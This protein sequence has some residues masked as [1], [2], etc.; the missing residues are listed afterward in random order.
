MTHDDG[1]SLIRFLYYA[2]WFDT[3]AIIVTN[4]LPDFKH[5]DTGPWDKAMGILNAYKEDLPQLRKHDSLFPNYEELLSKTKQGRGALP[6]IW[7]TNDLKFSGQI[8][9]RYVESKWDSINFHDWIGEG[10]NPNGESKDSEGSEFLQQVFDKDDDRPIYVQAWGGPI[11]LVQALYRYKQRKGDEKLK[12]ILSK[13]HIYG[14]LF[15]DITFE[16]FIDF[17]SVKNKS[18]GGFGSAIPTYKGERAELGQLLYDPGHFWQ[19][20]CSSDSNWVR[21]IYAKEFKGHGAMSELFDDYGEGDT[22]SFLYLISAKL[23]LNDPL[24][25]TQGSWGNR[26]SQMEKPF[27]KGYYHSCNHNAS[28][29][30]RWN[31]EAKNSF[32][33]RLL[34]SV[35]N[36]EE[37]NREPVAV[38]NRDNSNKIIT[39]YVTPGKSI[40]LDATKSSDTDRDGLTF[41]W[42]RYDEADNYD[43][44]FGLTEPANAIQ[45]L[46]VPSDLNDKN[47]HLVL[48]V[49]DNGTP[50]LAVYRRV[51]IKAENN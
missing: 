45:K 28:E 29:L 23:G 37:V 34:W 31:S 38:V 9:S 46:V 30:T 42:F 43:G 5:T 51:I 47:I 10:L 17:D 2:P 50:G 20:C 1:N 35:K 24:D 21:P 25:P 6:I 19:Y 44:S 15:Q 11:T 7:L 39:L 48:Q 41:K 13:L 27:P 3:E 40:T 33:N 49:S 14:I 36:P 32:Q 8:G 12:R 4:Q 18:C 26:F 22:P 16:Y